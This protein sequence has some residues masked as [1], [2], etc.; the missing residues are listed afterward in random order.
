[1]KVSEIISKAIKL[2]PSPEILPKLLNVLQDT[3]STYWEIAKLIHLDQSLTAQV[4]NW[5][6]SGYYGY[7]EKSVN[8]EEAIGRV[9]TK[10]VYKLVG[11]VMGKRLMKDKVEF[12]GLDA[13]QLWET[14]LAAAFSME[15]LAHR[16]GEDSNVCYTIGLLHSIGKLVIGQVCEKGY[17]EV[18][19][20][21][22]ED[23]ISL[24]K[25]EDEVIGC[26]HAQVGEALLVKWNF[27]SDVSEPVG[28]QYRPSLAQ[29]YPTT[30]AMMNLTHFILSGVGQNFG[31]SSH[32]FEVDPNVLE[33]LGIAESD[34]QVILMEAL[35]KIEE[36]KSLV[37]EQLG[38]V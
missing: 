10:E 15:A 24:V 16:V 7:S 5:S 31:R 37:V 33:K 4:L 34:L 29:K 3:E 30:A 28:Y 2:P 26:N 25:A 35:A 6:N 12:Y 18:F 13:G 14:S 20:K 22:E 36:V 8:I 11:L 19:R 1:M 21:V 38:K 9:G 32:A 27:K 17:E 23:D